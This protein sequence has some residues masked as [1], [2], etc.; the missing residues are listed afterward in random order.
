MIFGAAQQHTHTSIPPAFQHLRADVNGNAMGAV[1]SRKSS[2]DNTCVIAY[3]KH[4]TKEFAM[5]HALKLRVWM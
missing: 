4:S 2:G 5:T 3:R 1:H